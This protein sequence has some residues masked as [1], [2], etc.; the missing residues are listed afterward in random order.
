MAISLEIFEMKTKAGTWGFIEKNSTYNRMHYQRY[1]DHQNGL[2]VN[3][4]AE[5]E[6]GCRTENEVQRQRA[7]SELSLKS[8]A[9]RNDSYRPLQRTRVNSREAAATSRM[10]I[11][12]LI[13]GKTE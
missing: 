3:V 12:A 8:V 11:E 6:K 7:A 5:V 13:E 4:I 9:A 2:L 10:Q 1:R